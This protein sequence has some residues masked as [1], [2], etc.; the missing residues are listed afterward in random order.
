MRE[1]L[2]Q[3]NYV[4]QLIRSKPVMDAAQLLLQ[5]MFPRLTNPSERFKELL[6]ASIALFLSVQCSKGLEE[7]L[8]EI[9]ESLISKSGKI[10]G[11]SA[12]GTKI[13]AYNLWR[14]KEEL[15]VREW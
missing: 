12:F 6:V 2:C 11:G 1:I 4:L 5:E 15:E 13:N 14:G 8:K 10:I 3:K 9:F 7:K